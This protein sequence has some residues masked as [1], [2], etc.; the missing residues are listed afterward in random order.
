LRSEH[1]FRSGLSE[2]ELRQ[3]AGIGSQMAAFEKI[4]LDEFDAVHLDSL[5]ALG[6]GFFVVPGGFVFDK[7]AFWDHLLTRGVATAASYPESWND[8]AAFLD[9]AN[10]HT[11]PERHVLVVR[12]GP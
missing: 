9:G 5:E 3:I 12:L 4:T 8:H 6:A 1:D 11:G 10:R 7:P 2:S